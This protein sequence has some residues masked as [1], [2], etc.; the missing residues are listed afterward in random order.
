MATVSSYIGGVI[1]RCARYLPAVHQTQIAID[2]VARLGKQ[3]SSPALF[4]SL[5]VGIRSPPHVA[6]V[7]APPER[8]PHLIRS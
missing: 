3:S 7:G 5:L 6:S 4:Q 2:C 8:L 1:R